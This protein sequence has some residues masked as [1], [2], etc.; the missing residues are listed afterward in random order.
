MQTEL[1]KLLFG[2]FIDC[3]GHFFENCEQMFIN[4]MVVNMYARTFESGE[5]IMRPGQH[6]D[7]MYFIWQGQVVICEPTTYKEPFCVLPQYSFF[8]DY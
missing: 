1:V 3:F 2:D 7:E 5:D 4:E 6:F 8:G